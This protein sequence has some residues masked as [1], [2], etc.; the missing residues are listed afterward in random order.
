MVCF[1]KVKSYRCAYLKSTWDRFSGV[2]CPILPISKSKKNCIYAASQETWLFLS[3]WSLP[4]IRMIKGWYS[5]WCIWNIL[6]KLPLSYMT[7][8]E[9]YPVFMHSM[10]AAA[11]NTSSPRACVQS[12]V[13]RKSTSS[14]AQT[15]QCLDAP[16]AASDSA[17]A[18]CPLHLW[19]LMSL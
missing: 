5:T 6:F 7:Q 8:S 10:D 18:N 16:A 4:L 1:H 12:A 19:T 3:H 11:H 2:F 14:R 13:Q 9:S 15:H 17:A